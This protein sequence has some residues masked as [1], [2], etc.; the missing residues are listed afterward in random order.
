MKG[1]YMEIIYFLISETLNTFSKYETPKNT[2]KTES[3]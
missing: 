3:L 1:N 2:I